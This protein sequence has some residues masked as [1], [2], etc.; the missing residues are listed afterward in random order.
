MDDL[1]YETDDIVFLQLLGV[2]DTGSAMPHQDIYSIRVGVDLISP[3][4]YSN[5]WPGQ[6]GHD[7]T[8]K[9]G[10]WKHTQR[11][12]LGASGPTQRVKSSE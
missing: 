9:T 8:K 10:R 3:L 2:G 7:M 4:H 5:S 12:G 11:Q 1:E 6:Q